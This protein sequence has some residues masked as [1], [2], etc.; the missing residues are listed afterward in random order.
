MADEKQFSKVLYA[1]E[2]VKI[3]VLNEEAYNALKGTLGFSETAPKKTP[4]K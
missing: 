1:P 2:G 4:A 3:T